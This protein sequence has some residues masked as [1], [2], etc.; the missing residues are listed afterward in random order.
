MVENLVS[1]RLFD[2]RGSG[3]EGGERSQRNKGRKHTRLA[4][5]ERESSRY[6]PTE[7]MLSMSRDE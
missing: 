4:Q 2:A 1:A 5:G 6:N 3:P 7:V